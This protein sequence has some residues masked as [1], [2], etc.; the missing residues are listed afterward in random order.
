MI[1]PNFMDYYNI[2]FNQEIIAK[3]MA[4]NSFSNFQ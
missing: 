3:T 4:S 2:N 1:Y